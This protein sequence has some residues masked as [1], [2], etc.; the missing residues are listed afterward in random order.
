MFEVVMA[1]FIMALIIVGVVFLST[2]SI[3]NSAFSRNKTIAGRYSQE[4]V[5]WLRGQRDSDPTLF[6]TN[7]TGT[8]CLTSLSFTTSPHVACSSANFITGTIFKRQVVFSVS[9]AGCPAN[10][11]N[12]ITAEVTTS[13]DDSKGTHS[14]KSTTEFTDIREK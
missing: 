9:L 10:C 6:V 14:A 8:W 13:W 12:V 7:A 5:E 11:K 4:A 2:S 3:A 1:L